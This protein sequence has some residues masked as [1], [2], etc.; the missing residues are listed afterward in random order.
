METRIRSKLR[1][2][3][4]VTAILRKVRGR[5]IVIMRFPFQSY[6]SIILSLVSGKATNRV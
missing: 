4:K 6:F 3:T 1:L 5:L 2:V